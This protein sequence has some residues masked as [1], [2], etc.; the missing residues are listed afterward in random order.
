MNYAKSRK[1]DDPHAQYT[2][3]KGEYKDKSYEKRTIYKLNHQEPN[4]TI[5]RNCTQ[6]ETKL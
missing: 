2:C 4:Y 5:V 6:L 1:T 3:V